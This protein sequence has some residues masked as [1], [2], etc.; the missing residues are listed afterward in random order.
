MGHLL[1]HLFLQAALL[2]LSPPSWLSLSASQKNATQLWVPSVFSPVL[3]EAMPSREHA[4]LLSSQESELGSKQL[5]FLWPTSNQ[6][7]IQGNTQGITYFGARCR[8]F[9]E[10]EG[11]RGPSCTFLSNGLWI[12]SCT[13]EK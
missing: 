12:T 10:I 9:G 11:R 5:C 6:S 3:R 8:A 7:L 4:D 13:R 2:H 1:K